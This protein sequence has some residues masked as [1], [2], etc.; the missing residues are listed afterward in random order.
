M[1]YFVYIVKCSDRSLYTGITT[2]IEK[3]LAQHNG[4]TKGGAKYTKMHRPVVLVY[5][6][7]VASRSEATV[8]EHQIKELSRKEKEELIKTT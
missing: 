4:V 5:S 1:D 7:T 8:R 3:R 2:D 6:E